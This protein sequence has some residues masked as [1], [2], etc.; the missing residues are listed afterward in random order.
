MHRFFNYITPISLLVYST[1]WILLKPYLGDMLDSDA[2][3][4]LTIAD[5]V[6]KGDY[7]NSVNGLWSPLNAWLI[8]PFIQYG[9]NAWE[10]AKWL[11]FVFRAFNLV[12]FY[13]MLCTFQLNAFSKL[14]LM[15]AA[16]I[17]MAFA[18]YFQVFGDVLQ[19]CFV[20]A[21]LLLLFHHGSLQKNIPLYFVLC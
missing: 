1:L 10:I 19:L 6:A 15:Q 18:V 3:A 2:T 17:F 4:Y 12:L 5:R 20:L 11:N 14:A 7:A 9:Y 8:A 16:S 21:Y 13:R